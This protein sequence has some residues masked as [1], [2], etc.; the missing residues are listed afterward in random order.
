MKPNNSSH[1]ARRRRGLVV[2]VLVAVVAG[3]VALGMVLTPLVPGDDAT[4]RQPAGPEASRGSEQDAASRAAA[5]RLQKLARRKA[6]DPMALGDVDAPVVMVA[7]SDFQCPF[8][9][10][11]ARDIEPELVKR[12]V[13]KGTLRIE[14]RDF[15]YLGE[16]STTA[17][18]AGRAAAMQNRFWD[19]HDA[20]YAEQ[21]RVNTGRWTAD[22]LV[23]V[24]ADLG[25][26]VERFRRDMSSARAAKL[27]RHDF[28]EGQSI[29]VTGTP[30]FLVNGYPIMGALPTKVF[31]DAVEQA[32]ADA[33]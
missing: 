32:A 4:S 22:Y 2:P 28:Q 10:K 33:R 30:A 12:Y 23:D 3:V 26:D 27:V 8:C 20:L 9:G 6:D 21:P 31:V 29:G 1:P 24:A 13:R 15:P 19:F 5:E 14:W 25:L 11:Y 18:K 17:A 16:E 7:Y